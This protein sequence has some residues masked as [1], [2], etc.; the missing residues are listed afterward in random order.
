MHTP[1]QN[2]DLV[3]E[4][5][6]AVPVWPLTAVFV[7]GVMG[8]CIHW[9]WPGFTGLAYWAIWP[10]SIAMGLLLVTL[11]SARWTHELR[12]DMLIA[13]KLLGILGAIMFFGAS[14]L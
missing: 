2:S 7:G 9:L 10:I 12:W 4:T 1:Y 5:R 14:F 13:G 11:I 3:N 8:V 6:T